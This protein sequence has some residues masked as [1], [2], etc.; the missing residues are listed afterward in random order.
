MSKLARYGSPTNSAGKCTGSSRLVPPSSLKSLTSTSPPDHPTCLDGQNLDSD[1][2][3]LPQKYSETQSPKCSHNEK[4]DSQGSS[5]GKHGLPSVIPKS[6]RAVTSRSKASTKLTTFGKNVGNRDKS[7]GGGHSNSSERRSHSHLPAGRPRLASSGGVTKRNPPPVY[8]LQKRNSFES[9]TQSS[10]DYY[11]DVK[12]LSIRNHFQKTRSRAAL[13]ARAGDSTGM[14]TSSDAF[15]ESDVYDDVGIPGLRSNACPPNRPKLYSPGPG[16]E[17]SCES[18]SESDSH[19]YEEITEF[20]SPKTAA[21]SHNY[22]EIDDYSWGDEYEE[23]SD[24]EEDY[25]D[26]VDITPDID[27]V[28]LSEPAEQNQVRQEH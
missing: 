28:Q 25:L 9:E 19:N 8:P 3:N 18:Q 16:T 4:H 11:E 20:V 23:Y 5:S 6:P 24:Y 12:I 2:V 7:S 10:S 17:A 14:E 1:S 27:D 15:S 22:E 21:K 26:Q 13:L